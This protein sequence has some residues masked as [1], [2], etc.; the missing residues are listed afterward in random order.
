M[1]PQWEED[2]AYYYPAGTKVLA[3]HSEI[4]TT[5]PVGEKEHHI[6][7]RQASKSRL[8]IKPLLMDMVDDEPTVFFFVV[9][10]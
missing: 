8:P 3:P 5:I 2:E 4:S 10:L 9:L 6:T 1:L 7:A